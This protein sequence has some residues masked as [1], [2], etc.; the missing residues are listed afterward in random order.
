[1]MTPLSVVG[2]E[3]GLTPAERPVVPAMRAP[4]ATV[5]KQVSVRPGLR[6]H[7]QL[8][9]GPDC[10]RTGVRIKL[11]AVIVW[12][13]LVV[14]LGLVIWSLSVVRAAAGADAPAP[15]PNREPL[16]VAR[17]V[18]GAQAAD[19]DRPGRAPGRRARRDG[20]TSPTRTSGRRCRSS[21]CW[22][23]S[24]SARTSSCSTPSA[25]GSAARSPAWC[26]RWRCSGPAPAAVA[27]PRLGAGRRDCA[28]GVRGTYLLNNLL[29]YTT[30]P[31]LGGLALHALKQ[32]DVRARAATRS[33]SSSSSSPPTR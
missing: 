32:A 21:A 29:T 8:R 22:R 17:S 27:R 23:C 6:K 10:A 20:A 5:R 26:W 13:A 19:G 3:R 9:P 12:I 28:G 4:Y 2:L 30:F 24:C 14:W 31:L 1:M 15:P 18:R 7:S 25:S 11:L 16:P 33:R